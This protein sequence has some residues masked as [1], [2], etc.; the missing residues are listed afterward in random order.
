MAC[1]CW[2]CWMM[3][4]SIFDFEFPAKLI[5]IFLGS[6]CSGRNKPCRCSQWR[7]RS[8][9]F[10]HKKKIAGS[11]L[12]CATKKG[13]KIVESVLHWSL[14]IIKLLMTKR[15]FYW[16]KSC[17]SF[18]S[19]FRHET[20]TVHTKT[21]GRFRFAEQHSNKGPPIR[22]SNYGG[23]NFYHWRGRLYYVLRN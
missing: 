19:T 16:P 8:R 1:H 13:D 12:W 18:R 23:N 22:F 15:D 21:Q 2:S 6:Y 5:W 3:S 10:Q 9:R 14:R 11:N 7:I 17:N 4:R 20:F